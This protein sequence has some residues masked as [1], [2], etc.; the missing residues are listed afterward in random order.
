MGGSR[1]SNAAV[2]ALGDSGLNQ[3]FRSIL[4]FPTH[5]LPNNAVITRVLLMIR[6]EGLVGADPFA[7]HGSIQVDIRSG[8]FGFIGPFP[9][10]GLQDMDFQSPSHMDAVG[11]IQNNPFDGWYWA[12]INASA[13]P[14]I[15]RYGITQLRLEFQIDDDNDF[16]DDY[17]RFY[18]GD[19][20]EL[21]FRP[22][23]VVEYYL[24]R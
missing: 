11:Y 21:A 15:N 17:L 18:S 10:R 1:N 24:Q 4:N 20:D 7:T 5:Y 3:Q 23:L 16:G 19:V 14:Y 2:F 13:F 6:K 22:R 8:A 9:Y 12:W